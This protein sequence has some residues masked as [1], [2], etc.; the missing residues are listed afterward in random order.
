M[1]V[2]ELDGSVAAAPQITVE[3]V[4]QAR[5]RGFRSIVN[6]RPDAEEPGQPSG[7]EIEA[8]AHAAGLSYAHVPLGREPISAAHIE[9]MHAALEAAERPALLYCRSGTRSTV[10]WALASAANGA[11]P[12]ALTDMA[13]EAGY[14]L[15]PYAELMASLASR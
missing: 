15:S 10:L 9:A 5:A 12:A 1:D 3:E 6:N 8:A 14:D 2:R 13:A 11:D 4:A 7:A